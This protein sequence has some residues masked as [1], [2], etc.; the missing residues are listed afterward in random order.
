MPARSRSARSWSVPPH[1]GDRIGHDAAHVDGVEGRRS[2]TDVIE[3]PIH[4]FRGTLGLAIGALQVLGKV[5][6]LG[7]LPQRAPRALQ[8]LRSK[9]H[10]VLQ[11]I[12]ELVCQP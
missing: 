12:P 9:A 1:D 5:D 6:E 2:L 3:Q 11:R 10:Q 4:D 7:M 8:E